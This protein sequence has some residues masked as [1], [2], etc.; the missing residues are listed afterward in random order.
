[1]VRKRLQ[2]TAT[3]ATTS[4][5]TDVFQKVNNTKAKLQPDTVVYKLS[6]ATEQLQCV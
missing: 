6:T 3:H 2:L 4:V 1:M 5:S